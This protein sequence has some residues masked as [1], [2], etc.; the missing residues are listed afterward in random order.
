M[1]EYFNTKGAS[2]YLKRTPA[3]IR[4]LVLRRK[5]PFRKAGGRLVFLKEELDAWVRGS[6]GVRFED[7]QNEREQEKGN[8]S[9]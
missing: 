1:A 8:R 3:S 9:K 4:N 6:E 5:M 7:L 2:E